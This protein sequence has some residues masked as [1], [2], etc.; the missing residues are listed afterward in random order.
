MRQRFGHDALEGGQAMTTSQLGKAVIQFGVM[1][2][3]ALQDAPQRQ[4]RLIEAQ[5]L[6]I[7]P[8]RMEDPIGQDRRITEALGKILE[9]LYGW[10]SS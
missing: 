7:A 4:S 3:A 9:Q 1:R 2:H 6:L 5:V 10:F 8:D